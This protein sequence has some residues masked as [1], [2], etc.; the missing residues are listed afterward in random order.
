MSALG[1]VA[2]MYPDEVLSSGC[3]SFEGL[4]A[5]LIF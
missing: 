5:T 2:F 1:Q 3:N 4:Y